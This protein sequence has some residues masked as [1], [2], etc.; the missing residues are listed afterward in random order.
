MTFHIY[1]AQPIPGDV[2]TN[3]LVSDWV[4]TDIQTDT[5]SEQGVKE[6]GHQL[7]TK[8]GRIGAK[9]NSLE[10]DHMIQTRKFLVLKGLLQ[11]LFLLV[12]LISIG[13]YA[14]AESKTV[15]VKENASEWLEIAAL[16]DDE[17]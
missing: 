4:A 1:T 5:S 9:E 7:E 14:R 8:K 12:L 6:S 3:Y 15:V 13:G 11:Q 16:V 17:K 10:Q 2:F